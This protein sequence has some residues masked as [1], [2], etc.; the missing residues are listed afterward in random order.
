MQIPKT[1]RFGSWSW[2]G[3]KVT[4]VGLQPEHG[5]RTPIVTAAHMAYVAV[6]FSS[7]YFNQVSA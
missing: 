6:P 7:Y 1:L 4:Q 3:Y 5:W 2:A